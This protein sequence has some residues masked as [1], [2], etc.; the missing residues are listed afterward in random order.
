M[1]SISGYGQTGPFSSRVGLDI[2]GQ[3]AG[4]LMSLNGMTGGPPLRVANSL[5][6]FLAGVYAVYGILSAYIYKQ[7]TGLGQYVDCALAD[8]I[9]AILENVVPNYDLL[10]MIPKRDGSRIPWVAPLNSYNA[11]DGFVVIGV[12][13]NI[14]WHRLLDEMGRSDLHEEP[15]F[16]T[17]STRVAN[18]DTVDAIVQEWVGNLTVD[19][20]ID[21]LAK[22]G[23]PCSKVND[24]ASLVE[25]PQV[26]AREM[27]VETEY[28]GV[29]KFR[30]A[31]VTPKLSLTPGKIHM[32]VPTIGQHTD[33]ILKELLSLTPDKITSLREKGVI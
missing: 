2:V 4:G 26:I 22:A 24:V 31:G 32:P 18:V 17:P 14:L 27:L 7:K 1:A 5:A 13:G 33:D 8:N 6:D 20:V 11:K 12:T 23:V 29:G 30:V 9:T 15:K 21:Q 3:A 19:E 10:G 28:P 16:E 25:D